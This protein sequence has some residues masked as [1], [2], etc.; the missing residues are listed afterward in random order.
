MSRVLA[1]TFVVGLALLAIGMATP[2]SSFGVAMVLVAI[3]LFAAIAIAVFGMA[4][5]TK[6]WSWP[7]WRDPDHRR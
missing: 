2:S 1:W 3:L 5:R 4:W 7:P 6:G